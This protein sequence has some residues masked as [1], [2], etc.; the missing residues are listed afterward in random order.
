MMGSTGCPLWNPGFAEKLSVL[1]SMSI[2][3]LSNALAI[4]DQSWSW[5]LQLPTLSEPSLVSGLPS[6]SLPVFLVG[7]LGSTLC[8]GLTDSLTEIPILPGWT[9]RRSLQIPAWRRVLQVSNS[10]CVAPP[11]TGRLSLV[12]LQDW[13]ATLPRNKSVF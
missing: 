12:R 9:W 2:L 7:R 6:L 4:S 8:E 1:S 3:A 11:N 10:V 13:G 5:V